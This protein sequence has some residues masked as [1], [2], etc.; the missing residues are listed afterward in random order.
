MAFNFSGLRSNVKLSDFQDDWYGGNVNYTGDQQNNI[1]MSDL[2]T[3]PT[4]GGV[5][6]VV[7]RSSVSFSHMGGIRYTNTSGS[8]TTDAL[9]VLQAHMRGRY[10]A[11]NSATPSNQTLPQVQSGVTSGHGNSVN[12]RLSDYVGLSD[13]VLTTD[14]CGE[15]RGIKG[16]YTTSASGVGNDV[17]SKQVGALGTGK[18]RNQDLTYP[19]VGYSVYRTEHTNQWTELGLNTKAT[20]GDRIL[21]VACSAGGTMYTFSTTNPI[22][23]RNGSSSISHTVSTHMQPVKNETGTDDWIAV[24]SA[25]VGS[26]ATANRVGVNPYHS[27]A[28]RYMFH[29]FVIKGPTVNI[30]RVRDKGKHTTQTHGVALDNATSGQSLDTTSDA[31]GI[32]TNTYQPFFISVVSSPFGSN[33]F[34]STGTTNMG[35]RTANGIGF[36]QQFCSGVSTIHNVAYYTSICNFRGGTRTISFSSGKYSSWYGQ[37]E[38]YTPQFGKMIPRQDARQLHIVGSR[39]G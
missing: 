20:A 29:V 26:G 16:G 7:G 5:T 8:T 9:P 11:N 3:V 24:Y 38:G 36:D 39:G 21:V 13:C 31:Y 1:K 27:S 14:T 18:G 33:G 35:N 32:N 22:Y 12:A 4:T 30:N 10:K 2:F 25:V 28:Q 6:Y 17:F 37:F 23:L 15:S 19:E 34:S